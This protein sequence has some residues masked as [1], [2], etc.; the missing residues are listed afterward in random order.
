VA[1]A[2]TPATKPIRAIKPNTFNLLFIQ[3]TFLF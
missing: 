3:F 2:M 1:C